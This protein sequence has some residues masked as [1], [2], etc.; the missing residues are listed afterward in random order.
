VQNL[1]A[2]KIWI[3]SMSETSLESSS[4]FPRLCAIIGL[5]FL[6]LSV[7]GKLFLDH[8]NNA[9]N[10]QDFPQYYMA[11]QIVAH[12]EWDSLYPIPIAPETANPG[13]QKHSR[14]R[15]GYAKLA[16][17]YGVSEESVR[18]ISPPPF[19][20]LMYPLSWMPYRTAHVV[21]V[22][23]L[24]LCAWG[25]SL[26]A[27]RMYKLCSGTS[28]LLAG[29][30]ILM[31]CISPQAFRWA[32]VANLSVVMGLLI[33]W[34]VLEL[35]QR[36]DG[37]RGAIPIALGTISKYIMLVFMP[38]HL[39]A[40]QWRTILW[41]GVLCIAML[42]MSL[43]IMG[44]GPFEI[45][46]RE[47]SPTFAHTTLPERNNALHAFMLRTLGTQADRPLLNAPW[48]M[49]FRTMRIVVLLIIL[50]VIFTRKRSHWKDPPNLLSA[51]LALITW[52][53]IFSPIFW[54]HYHA[55]FAPFWGYLLYEASRSRAR[56]VVCWS[57]IALAWF[58]IQL[59]PGVRIPEPLHSHL[60]VSALLMMGFAICATLRPRAL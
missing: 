29:A 14:L 30:L 8:R 27:A 43:L 20:L 18:F 5:L 44:R 49:I 9:V 38:L 48:E 23:G 34:A 7:N 26:L 4:R 13:D 52:V 22:N 24:I 37:A 47:I 53:T 16:R 15:E 3:A 40:R 41:T 10:P 54:E 58:P 50:A 31:I 39:V 19:A 33:G 45:F 2:H 42:G 51:A 57:A 1:L 17:R 28:P 11:G 36:R 60:L 6:L 32:R 25:I 35:A 21:W 56:A 46:F 12:G 55:Y 59:I